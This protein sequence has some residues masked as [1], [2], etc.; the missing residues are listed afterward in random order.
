MDNR[1]AGDGAASFSSCSNREGEARCDGVGATIIDGGGGGCI[2]IG[3]TGNN[4]GCGGCK[5]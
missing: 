2:G 1:C 3:A 4:N 5:G